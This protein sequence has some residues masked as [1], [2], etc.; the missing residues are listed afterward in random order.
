[1]NKRF[2]ICAAA[3]L[4]ASACFG[5]AIWDK[6][7][8]DSVRVHIDRPAYATA[9]KSLIQKA[10][11]LLGVTPLSVMDKKRP[12]PSGDNHDYTSLAR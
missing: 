8:L 11:C 5:Q 9:Y 3:L 12:A 2:A 7:H 10:D 4:A 6:S 1:M